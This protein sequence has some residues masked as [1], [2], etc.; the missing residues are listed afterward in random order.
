MES[1]LIAIAG[2]I[3][4]IGLFV[5]ALYATGKVIFHMYKLVTNVTGTYASLFGAFLLFMPSQFN[6]EGNAN[7]IILLRWLPWVAISYVVLFG[8]NYVVGV[9]K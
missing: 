9:V 8:L 1:K 5:F 3:V 6:E 2:I 7:R 4:L